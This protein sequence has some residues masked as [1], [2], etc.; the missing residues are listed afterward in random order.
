M[1]PKIALSSQVRESSPASS[2][3]L[4]QL[5]DATPCHAAGIKTKY[6]RNDLPPYVV[7][8][9]S[10]DSEDLD[11]ARTLSHPLWISQAVTQCVPNDVLSIDKTGRGKVVVHL[12]SYHAANRLIED[13][14]LALKKLKALT[15][16][17]PHRAF[18]NGIIRGVSQDLDL[19]NVQSSIVSPVK[20]A[21]ISRL[22]RKIRD[23]DFYRFVP[24]RSIC[25]KFTGQQ[26]PRF[27]SIFKVRHEVLPF[28]PQVKV[29]FS[30]YKIGHVNKFCRGKP[31]CIYC[32]EDKHAESSRCELENNPPCCLSCGG[33]HLPTSFSCPVIQ[34]HR[35]IQA[36]LTYYLLK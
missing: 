30:C 28:I 3:P 34:R 13:R 22:N 7:Q 26:L 18:R 17:P 33:G 4:S 16:S 11:N 35:E 36:L 6:F 24:S 29:C 32:G 27:I 20:I 10:V 19:D 31:R 12:S 15:P 1:S 25:I 8:V 23:G 9:Q 2:S 5:H 21:Q 14:S